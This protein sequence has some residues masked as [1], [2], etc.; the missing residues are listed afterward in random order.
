MR[1][2][3]RKNHSIDLLFTVA[4]FCMFA[5]SALVILIAGAGVYRSVNAR[6]TAEYT[7]FTPLFY[8]E[9]KIHQHDRTGGVSL[10][11]IEDQD[12][13]CLHSEY[14]GAAYTTY[15]FERDDTLQELFIRAD[16]QPD[17]NR[18]TKLTELKEMSLSQEGDNILNVTLTDDSGALS[19]TR[20]LVKAQGGLRHE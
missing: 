3:H 10:R 1:N 19:S 12:V 6:A 18:G 13:L 17:L 11:Q 16:A 7:H 20:V 14:N 8:I 5:L 2:Y 4:L 9:Q 15:I